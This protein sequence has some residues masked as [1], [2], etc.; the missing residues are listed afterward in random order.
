MSQERDGRRTSGVLTH[1]RNVH[2]TAKDALGSLHYD[3]S[4]PAFADVV[5]AL[6]RVV[7]DLEPFKRIGKGCGRCG[8]KGDPHQHTSTKYRW[9]YSCEVPR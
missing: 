6:E 8:A 9:D 4:D 1:A 5:A 2:S 7:A 3:R